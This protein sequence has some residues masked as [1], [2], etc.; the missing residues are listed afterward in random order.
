MH[1]GENSGNATRV[2]LTGLIR[3]ARTADRINE[4]IG[5]TRLLT[6]KDE[7]WRTRLAWEAGLPKARGGGGAGNRKKKNVLPQAGGQLRGGARG[8]LPR[9]KNVDCRSYDKKSWPKRKGRR[10]GTIGLTVLSP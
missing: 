2:G 3:L 1:K 6:W 4:Q 8:V 9:H 10:I 5:L 7:L